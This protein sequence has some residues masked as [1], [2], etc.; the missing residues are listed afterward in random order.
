M[1]EELTLIQLDHIH[2]HP[3]NPRKD[4]GD[5]TELAD[6]IKKNGLL[7]NLTVVPI[8]G[9]PDE[10]T[11]I[12]GHRRCGAAKLAGLTEVPCKVVEGMS[13]K[14][15]FA[16]MME[17]NMQRNDLTITEQ[18]QGFQMMIDLGETEESIAEKT[19][20]SK[21][22][23]K[24]RLNIAKLDQKKLQK[25]EKDEDFQLSLKDLYLLEKIEDVEARNKILSEADDSRSLAYKVTIAVKDQTRIKNKKILLD[26]L[27]PKGIR[28]VPSSYQSERWTAKWQEVRRFDLLEDVKSGIRIKDPQE[29]YYSD[30]YGG[31]IIV[32]RVEEDKKASEPTKEEIEKKRIKKNK[33]QIKAITSRTIDRCATLALGVANGDVE[34]IK[35]NSIIEDT[36]N[37][38]LDLGVGMYVSSIVSIIA[39][40]P[41]YDL[42]KEEKENTEK[43]IKN[44][45]MQAKLLLFMMKGMDVDIVAYDGTYKKSTGKAVMK[46]F[47]ILEK[48]GFRFEPEEKAVFD[49]MSSLYVRDFKD[50]FLRHMVDMMFLSDKMALRGLSLEEFIKVETNGAKPV[51]KT[52][53]EDNNLLI[54]ADDSQYYEEGVEHA[55]WKEYYDVFN[56]MVEEE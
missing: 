22:T 14:E 39:K 25:I 45:T 16:T 56:E 10:Y 13:D 23:I 40:K 38:V 1:R 49:G 30:Y 54:I 52:Y 29:C 37:A 6:S 48:Y 26:I 8:D 47:S 50:D 17:E 4:L 55:S 15:Q 11:A 44:M 31:I 32:R 41:Y 18:A 12:I 35:D 36:F 42:E 20:F 46:C 33:N 24:R 5:L 9:E 21:T 27:K 34:E 3:D 2:P 51:S 19:G 7:Q 53:D 28:E 43:L